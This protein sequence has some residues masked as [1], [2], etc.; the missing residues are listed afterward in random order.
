MFNPLEVNE[1]LGGGENG[2]LSVQDMAMHTQYSGGYSKNDPAVKLFWK[3]CIRNDLLTRPSALHL[4]CFCC[5]K[6][7]ATTHMCA[8][9]CATLGW[10]AL[11]CAM[12]CWTLALTPVDVHQLCP[13]RCA[14]WLEIRGIFGNRL[15]VVAERGQCTT[16]ILVSGCV[17][18]SDGLSLS[19]DAM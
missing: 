2:A 18:M 14:H 3:V 19:S 16:P 7:V 5:K 6:S 1:L 9:S 15:S 10:A 17:H 11:R 12:L 4:H 13:M 8:T